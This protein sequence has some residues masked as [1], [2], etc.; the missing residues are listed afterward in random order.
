MYAS[1]QT[2]NPQTQSG[3]N[4]D[5]IQDPRIDQALLAAG[6]TLDDRQRQAAYGS[7]S[8][9]I[10]ADEAVIPLYPILEVD[11]RKTYLQD[12]Q[13]NPNNWITWNSQD[14]WLNQ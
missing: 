6:N 13:S 14:W 3:N 4:W 12:W 11:A 10:H 8:Q 9:L 7:F 5:R 1:N 2:P